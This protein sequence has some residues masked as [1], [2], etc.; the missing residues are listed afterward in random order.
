M[1]DGLGGVRCG[2]EGEEV[3]LRSTSKVK[4]GEAKKENMKT[5][6]DRKLWDILKD[7]KM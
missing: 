2:G 3:A 5:V 4:N 7:L 1:E 6:T